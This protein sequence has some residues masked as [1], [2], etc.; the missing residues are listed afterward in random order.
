MIIEDLELVYDDQSSFPDEK[1][2]IS[3]YGG[4]LRAS[5]ALARG[6]PIM[7]GYMGAAME[8]RLHEA[9]LLA[10]MEA[11][12]YRLKW[13]GKD[14]K[15]VHIWHGGEEWPLVGHPD[16][17]IQMMSLDE[18]SHT[19]PWYLLELKS[20]DTHVFP[21]LAKYGSVKEAFPTEYAQVQGY[22]GSVE[23]QAEG[24]TAC[25]YICK[26]RGNG[27][28]YEEV[29]RYDPEWLANYLESEFGQVISGYRLGNIEPEDLPCHESDYVRRWCGNRYACEGEGRE[30]VTEET[31]KSRGLMAEW[32]EIA[33]SVQSWQE[34]HNAIKELE[35]QEETARKEIA[36]F[37]TRNGMKSALIH[38]VQA[39]M[40]KSSRSSLSKDV[41]LELGVPEEII[42]QATAT[43]ETEYLRLT[44]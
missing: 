21:R 40:V 25:M 30:V 19:T 33:E 10:R 34:A 36:S 38:D 13:H 15:E 39:T 42:K 6:K 41:L 8:G 11:K 1:W 2:R 26:C 3:G 28:L 23:V 32:T 31:A 27:K 4:C 24:V 22:M 7:K 35:T 44:A 16:G 12:G 17:L 20:K 18:D 5:L 43:K 9:D 29:I 14:Q 37:M